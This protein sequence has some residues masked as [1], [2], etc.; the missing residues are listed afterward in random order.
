MPRIQQITE[1]LWQTEILR[2]P[3]Q[4]Q[5]QPHQRVGFGPEKGRNGP[6]IDFV[7]VNH[8]ENAG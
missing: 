4:D 6:V 7:A 2:E 5:G 8:A 3:D 1:P